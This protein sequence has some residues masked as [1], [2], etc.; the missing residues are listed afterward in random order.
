M[1]SI[2]DRPLN[3]NLKA[4]ELTQIILEVLNEKKPQSVKHLTKILNE[5]FD[6]TDEEIIESVL[7]LQTEGTI[8][9]ENQNLQSRNLRTY[10]KS[11]AAIWYWVTIV[12]IILATL[13]FILSESIYPWIYVRNVLGL[14]F[15]LFLPGFAF[16][17][18]LFPIK[19]YAKSSNGNLEEIE[20]IALSIGMSI[21]L[22]STAGLLLYY[23]PWG[24]DFVTIIL[25]L[26]TFTLVSATTAIIK[27]Y[28]AKKNV[29]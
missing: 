13:V 19:I 12:V 2:K 7:K 16:I 18:A 4:S 3:K 27:E 23:S 29:L 9:F 21:A 11:G 6:F 8:L 20:H 15:I 28:R 22:V 25:F 1:V 10:L 5:D 14:I 24:L 26:V 17:K